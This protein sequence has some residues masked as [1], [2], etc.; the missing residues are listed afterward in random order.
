MIA[1]SSVVLP[2]PFG[3]DQGCD[4]AGWDVAG[5]FLEDEVF[6]EADADP[7]DGNRLWLFTT[8]YSRMV[9]LAKYSFHG[10][11]VGPHHPFVGLG[12]RLTGSHGF[13]R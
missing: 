2:A 4:P 5:H 1:R 6:M 11:Q 13:Q 8:G 9:S 7:F 3:T 10:F 12:S